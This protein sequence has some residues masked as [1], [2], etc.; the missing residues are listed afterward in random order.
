MTTRFRANIASTLSSVVVPTPTQ[1]ISSAAS[2]LQS[3]AARSGGSLPDAGSGGDGRERRRDGYSTGYAGAGT[4]Y[5]DSTMVSNWGPFVDPDLFQL[6]LRGLSVEESVE[7]ILTIINKPVRPAILGNW[8]VDNFRTAAMLE[9]MFF[10]RPDFFVPEGSQGLCPLPIELRAMMVDQYYSFDPRI[11]RALLGKKINSRTRK[12]LEDMADT[13]SASLKSATRRTL[14]LDGGAASGLGPLRVAG[15]RRV[16]DNLKRVTRRVEDT[17]GDLVVAVESAFC[18]RKELATQYALIIFLNALRIDT[19]KKKLAHLSFFDILSAAAVLNVRWCAP[20]GGRAAWVK[21]SAGSDSGAVLAASM[22]GQ[23]ASSLPRG[24]SF[25]AE[26]SNRSSAQ[27]PQRRGTATVVSPQAAL[28]F[29]PSMVTNVDSFDVTVAQDCRDL[30]TVFANAK[31]EVWEEMRGAVG[32]RLRGGERNGVEQEA[33]ETEGGGGSRH[34]GSLQ[35]VGG[36]SAASSQMPSEQ[37]LSPPP[38]TTIGGI[39]AGEQDFGGSIGVI[40]GASQFQAVPETRGGPQPS[41]PLPR[42]IASRPGSSRPATPS[43]VSASLAGTS[44]G[45][46]PVVI[47]SAPVLRSLV[48]AILLLGSTLSSADARDVLLT[49]VEKVCEPAIVAGMSPRDVRLV[50]HAAGEVMEGMET[51]QAQYRKRYGGTWR[52]IVGGA[53]EVVGH[54]W[55][56]VGGSGSEALVS[57]SFGGSSVGVHGGGGAVADPL[58]SVYGGRGEGGI[59][60]SVGS[61]EVLSTTTER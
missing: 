32:R 45:G 54:L 10:Q 41:S 27:V 58:Q 39:G 53:G 30:R 14:L 57:G 2:W 33:V 11:M 34:L 52:R 60:E 36:T 8:V 61:T 23:T 47:P 1:L 28:A 21:Q 49:L 5:G 16:F 55:R 56:K 26:A 6:W 48:R 59:G 22:K 46:A 31:A 51:V 42:A 20:A 17:D 9:Q 37:L 19:S 25:P 12:D 44:T 50:L 24:G 43:V 3:Q 18:L 29:Y 13:S 40:S 15:C 38:G 35:S 7:F 4:T